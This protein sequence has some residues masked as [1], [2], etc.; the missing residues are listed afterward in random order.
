LKAL[1]GHWNEKQ[2]KFQVDPKRMDA[3]TETDKNLQFLST[4]WDLKGFP[5]L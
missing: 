5:F 3:S 4:A 1:I 2:A